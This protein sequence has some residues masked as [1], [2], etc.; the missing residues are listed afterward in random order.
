MWVVNAAR[1]PEEIWAEGGEGG[2]GRAVLG[3]PDSLG[4]VTHQGIAQGWFRW[5]A[6]GSRKQNP[7][8]GNW[9]AHSRS[10]ATQ[11]QQVHARGAL[12]E[13]RGTAGLLAMGLCFSKRSV[14]ELHHL[15][16]LARLPGDRQ[17]FQICSSP[18]LY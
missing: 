5:S 2:W 18:L 6:K 15:R 13:G 10:P 4:W 8:E 14:T 16:R 1:V 11:V 3:K 17:R 7:W 12:R 9:A